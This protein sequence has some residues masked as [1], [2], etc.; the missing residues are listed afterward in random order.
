MEHWIFVTPF[1]LSTDDI[2]SLALCR[3]MLPA[4]AELGF[5]DR[6]KRLEMYGV[7]LY[8]VLGEDRVEYFLGSTPKG[9][10]V[11]RNKSKVATYLW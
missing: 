1:L 6:A 9:V 2:L 8:P 7:D 4:K 11:Y 3:G 10:V 5:L